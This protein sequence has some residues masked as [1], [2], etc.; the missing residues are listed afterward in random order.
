MD[1]AGLLSEVHTAQ[2]LGDAVTTLLH[3]LIQPPAEPLRHLVTIGSVRGPSGWV[4]SAETR[5]RRGA[6]LAM[7][8]V[9]RKLLRVGGVFA[10]RA[11]VKSPPQCR[12][13]EPNL[14]VVWTTSIE[15]AT[16]RQT[17]GALP[18]SRIPMAEGFQHAV[19]VGCW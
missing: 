5:K 19:S 4:V 9:A 18:V 15:D 16:M 14:I 13:A 2:P 1:F 12:E 6:A 17:T 3:H 7:D 10:I 11:G 8:F